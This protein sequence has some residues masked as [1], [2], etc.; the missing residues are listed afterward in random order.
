MRLVTFRRPTATADEESI[1]VLSVGGLLDLGDV[2]GSMLELLGTEGEGLRA[3]QAAVRRGGEILALDDVELRAPLPRPNSI[4]DFMLIEEHVRNSFGTVPDA[5]YEIPVYW[6]G[7]CD[8]VIGPDAQV[9]WPH[10]T[11]K[12]DFELEVA[13]IIGRRVWRATVEEAAD[14]IA[15]YTIFND[16]SARDIQFREMEVRLGPGLG[17]DFASSLGPCIATPD[18]FDIATA[19]MA[20]RVNGEMWAE[21]ALG[22]ML[23]TFPEVI[24]HLSQEQP[25]MPGD[26][27]GSGTVGCGCG[28]EL[29]R[30]IEPGDVVELEVQGIGVLRNVVG[31]RPTIVPSESITPRSTD[32]AAGS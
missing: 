10:Y 27:L 9:P 16:W 31:P 3:A 4:R 14:A 1:G 18:E 17:K 7:N 26:V 22:S 20:A 25:L 6:K 19:R 2:A 15:G 8:T 21:G 13:A 29:D 30:W 32:A 24:A 5:W 11:A 23:Y 28:L 12:L